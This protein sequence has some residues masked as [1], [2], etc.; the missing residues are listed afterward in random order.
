[1]TDCASFDEHSTPSLSLDSTLQDLS[2][3]QQQ[4]DLGSP[5]QAAVTLFEQHP[6]LPGIILTQQQEYTG[7][8]SRRQFFEQMSR[9]YS[10]E[11][12]SKRPLTLL[13]EFIQTKALMMPATSGITEA[14]QVALSRPINLAYDPIVVTSPAGHHVLGMQPL[15]VAHTQLHELLI[16]ALQHSETQLSQQADNLQQVL[17]DL[18][19]TQNHM[20]Q[21]E[22]MSALGQLVAGVAH[23]I[24]NP[25]NFI[26]GNIVP[27]N[28]Y[29]Q[30]L[31]RVV[32]AYQTHYPTPPQAVQDILDEIELDF[33]CEDLGKLLRSMKV[34]TDRIR[35]IVLSLRNFSR[36]DEAEFK[37]VDLHEGLDST[38]LILQHRLKAKPE[39]PAIEVVKEY[40]HL[41][42]VECYP[43]QINQVFMNLL[44]NAI[45]V[46][47]DAAQQ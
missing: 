26:H 6:R 23:E 5:G 22:K 20:I 7:L 11:L 33:V 37:A 25:I 44:A 30:D 10:L 28:G 16:K 2:L 1:M 36:L 14:A 47:D 18:K 29:A 19:R 39:S 15:L 8:L 46:L 21:S 42:L 32:Q 12:F 41:P 43:G 45:D 3:W 35:E 9:P 40:G 38:L 24:N 31:L 27:I 34:G 4:L 17:Y 13:H